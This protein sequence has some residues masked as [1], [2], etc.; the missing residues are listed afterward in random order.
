MDSGYIYILIGAFVISLVIVLLIH[1]VPKYYAQ[2]EGEEYKFKWTRF[3]GFTLVMTI[4]CFVS[5]II[6][7]KI[8]LFG[9]IVLI[10]LPGALIS[11]LRKGKM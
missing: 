1:L 10:G 7:V 9:I 4:I 11:F 5:F 8:G 2:K 3:V 6:F